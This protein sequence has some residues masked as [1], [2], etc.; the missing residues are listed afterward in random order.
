M[1]PREGWAPGSGGNRQ[2]RWTVIGGLMVSH[3][4]RDGTARWMGHL[5]TSSCPLGPLFTC[6]LFFPRLL[7]LRGYANLNFCTV[8]RGKQECVRALFGSP[9]GLG[10]WF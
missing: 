4:S 9:H 8:V 5:A 6:S 7:R 2:L 1:R 10:V 3:P